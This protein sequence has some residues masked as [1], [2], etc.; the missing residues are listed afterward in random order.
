MNANNFLKYCTG[1]ALVTGTLLFGSA[2]LIYSSSPAKAVLPNNTYATGK[3]QMQYEAVMDEQN[4]NWYV[5]V[6]D[7]ETGNSKT[8]YGTSKT[9]RMA[10]AGSS[11]QLPSSPL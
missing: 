2:A 3:Y 6:W 8:Y 7:T 10:V 11:F 9:G 4:M 1:I 5:L